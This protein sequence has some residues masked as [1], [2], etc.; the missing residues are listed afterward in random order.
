MI[1]GGASPI[2]NGPLVSVIMPVFDVEPYV[3]QA[4]RS[5]LAQTWADFELIAVD[6][7]CTDRSIALLEETCG[8]DPRVR[9][10][11]QEN[12]GLSAARNLGLRNAFGKF[13]YFFDSDDIL[14]A[15]AL[16]DCMSLACSL[17]LDLVAFS[18]SVLSEEMRDPGQAQSFSKPNILEPRTGELLLVELEAAGAYSPSPC[19]YVFSRSLLSSGDLRFAEGFLHEDEGFTPVLYC[20]A[21]RTISL[22]KPL[23]RRRLRPGS[24][25]AEPLGRRN[26][27]G[28]IEASRRI[29]E[30]QRNRNPTLAR[31]TR[32]TLTRLQRILLRSSLVRAERHSIPRDFLAE[33][34][35]RYSLPE[36]L[37]VDIAVAAYCL[38][39]RLIELSGLDRVRRRS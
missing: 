11:R 6:D 15:D 28:W 7:G 20:L 33:V 31:R 27:A 25:T 23:F 5:I 39:R 3:A 22:S 36:L 9:I 19:L 2:R 14:E 29:F 8:D 21:R 1:V 12:R 10:Y 35:Q 16:S 37:Q 32:R 26:I 17:D 38:G 18:G 24:I 30:F 34:R 4:V 13:V